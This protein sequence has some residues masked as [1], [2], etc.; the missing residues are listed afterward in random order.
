L[1][2]ALRCCK[3]RFAQ[4][5]SKYVDEA[6]ELPEYVRQAVDWLLKNK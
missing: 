3:A 2:A 4:I 1:K 6:T 5:S